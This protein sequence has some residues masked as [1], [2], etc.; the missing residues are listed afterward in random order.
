MNEFVTLRELSSSDYVPTTAFSRSINP[1]DHSRIEGNLIE[2]PKLLPS[3][4]FTNAWS[5]S[6]SDRIYIG[7]DLG[8][9]HEFDSRLLYRRSSGPTLHGITVFGIA[10]NAESIFTR[11]S[12]GNIVRWC[13]RTLCPTE[14]IST[15]FFASDT[16]PPAPSPSNALEVVGDELWVANSR[17]SISV[18]KIKT[19]LHFEREVHS[20]SRAFPERLHVDGD[21]VILCDVAGGV[22]RGVRSASELDRI[23]SVGAGVVHS[24]ARD[25]LY[26]RYWLTSDICGSVVLTSPDGQLLH[27]VRITNDDVEELVFSDDKSLCYVACFDH[28]IH[29][30]QNAAAPFAVDKIGPFKFQLSHLKRAGQNLLA[31]LESGEVYLVN[32]ATH[33]IVGSA[34][35]T[36]CIWNVHVG[37]GKL[38]CPTEAGDILTFEIG[39]HDRTGTVELRNKSSTPQLDYGRIRKAIQLGDGSLLLASTLGVLARRTLTGQLLWEV[40]LG[41]IIRDIS[42]S[43][44]SRYV[45]A[46][47]ES[48]FILEVDVANGVKANEFRNDR[49]VWCLIHLSDRVVAFGE[50]RMVDDIRALKTDLS[51][52]SSLDFADGTRST[53][54]EAKGNFKRLRRLDDQTLLVSSNTEHYVF[55]FNFR[56]KQIVRSF[57]EWIINTPENAIIVGGKLLVITYSQQLIQYDVT[58]GVVEDC[59]FSTEGYPKAIETIG[60]S[61]QPA[62]VLVFG[63]NFI[64]QYMLGEEGP[65]LSRTYYLS[66]F[67]ELNQNYPTK[68]ELALSRAS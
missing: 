12:S 29:I 56:E 23:F 17:G 50:R 45:V 9:I 37:S 21:D 62:S 5:D 28:Y 44:D 61:D 59:Q 55:I 11:D 51:R 19:S 27:Q 2:S 6:A 34:G 39:I 41:S 26:D 68:S 64:S 52:L 1:M 18:F 20:K 7:D 54:L 38:V 48:G 30:I 47:T 15:Q 13:R 4:R 25:T 67:R 14:F 49:P 43:P 63:R 31:I 42:L 35:G 57:K 46:G 65:C 3:T 58:T 32:P 33:D 24:I 40:R 22:W 60:G 8:R 53:L 36:D 10:G 16:N 66:G